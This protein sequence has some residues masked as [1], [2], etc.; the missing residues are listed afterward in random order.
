ML[1]LFRKRKKVMKRRKRKQLCEEVKELIATKKEP[2]FSVECAT[3][4]DDSWLLPLSLPCFLGETSLLWGNCSSVYSAVISSW[5][6]QE[7]GWRQGRVDVE[8][9]VKKLYY[10]K[11]SPCIKALGIMGRGLKKKR[12]EEEKKEICFRGNLNRMC[13]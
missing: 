4:Q 6:S 12:R 8:R 3:S 11:F 5:E 9:R 10:K 2:G 7:A 1:L 13:Q